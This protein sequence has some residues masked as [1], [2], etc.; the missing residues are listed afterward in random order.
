M[1]IKLL[2]IAVLALSF[3][4]ISF[5]QVTSIPQLPSENDSITIFF[6]AQLGSGNMKGYNG[7]LYTHTGVITNLSNGAWAYVIGT[8]G[9]NTQQPTLTRIGT[10]L[11]KLVIGNPH[12]Y[13][14]VP[15]TE[16]ILRLAFVFRSAD[17]K[18]Q[19]EDLFLPLFT[20]GLNVKVASPVA[21]FFANLNDSVNV[22]VSSSSA[23]S[24]SIYI[25]NTLTAQT[26]SS[27]TTFKVKATTTG[28][29]WIK[30]I[31]IDSNNFTKADSSY[32]VVNPNITVQ[33]E[34]TGIVD[35]I[36]YISNSSV[37]LSLY[38][39]QK[40]NVYVI[41]DFNNWIV[42]QNYY[43]KQTPDSSRW[44]IEINGLTP[45]KEYIFQYLVD[46]TINIADPYSE[47]ISDPNNDKYISDTTYPNL[48]QY[49]YGKTTQIASV[50]ETGQTPYQWHDSGFVP[51][52]KTNLVIYELLIRD[53][54]A[55][56]DYKTLA[57]TLSYFKRLGINAIELM[58]IMNFEGNDSWG[59][60][61]NF[62]D[63]PDKYYGP[64]DDLKKFIDMAHQDSIA[65]IL[66]IPF[67]DAFGS[68]PLVRLYWDPVNNIP[69]ANNPWFNQYPTH[70]YNV[71]YDFNHT[72]PAT[73]YFVDATTKFWLT[74]YH[75]DGFRFDLA[76]GYTQTYNPNNVGAWQSYDASR[77]IN[78]KRIANAIWNVSPGAYVILEEFVDG[79]EE[80]T[81][82]N[83]GMMVWDNM[84]SAY[85]QAAMGW[86]ANPSWDFSGISYKQWGWSVPGLVGYMESHDEERLMYKNLTY[87]NSNGSYNIKDL[88]TA[89]NRIK[90]CSAFFY[91]I[92]G[93]KMLW[94]F[95]ELGY[96]YS[97]N[98]NGRTGDKPIR[99]DYENDPRRMSLYKVTAAL[100]HLKTQ[101]PAFRSN[102]FNLNVSGAVK[103]INIYDNSMNVIVAGNFDVVN[104]TA[105]P[106]SSGT[107]YDYFTGS[108]LSATSSTSLNLAPGEFHIYTSVQLPV[109]DTSV[110]TDIKNNTSNQITNYA[111]DQNYP[112]PFNPSTIINYQLP[113]SSLVSLKIYDV[114][115]REVET[116]VNGEQ[117]S[118]NYTV[119]FNSS[120]KGISLPSGIYF[121]R[122]QAGSYIET[123]KMILMK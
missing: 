107:W 122:L 118:G 97:I 87:G 6:N 74:Q 63:A 72:S 43:M 58:P 30:A 105:T 82:A 100:I 32:F 41:G 75:A 104:H 106:F 88:E 1:K 19:T 93:P 9:N 29:T 84:S 95:Q 110:I 108:P 121:Y 67:N 37:I 86:A 23:K 80:D 65:V 103:Q 4:R 28:D 50:L 26:T 119:T 34:P 69:A 38:A 25:N 24:V 12:K 68:C 98:Y 8:W 17:A 13:Y 33:A 64:K 53:F 76:G 51:P 96:D 21:P 36:N 89:L 115:G 45:Q 91:T 70:P 46:G 102:G 112:N 42:D 81:V 31:A 109:P 62:F 61:P 49:P 15:S 71:G 94:E 39:P 2:L 48:I 16:K 10:D 92:P 83:Y 99:W 90:L 47:K 35:G 113:K 7:T 111:L 40:K 77:I 120:A 22:E 44:W 27:D 85:E 5:A 55:T 18:Q 14:G 60:N 78:Q 3:Y 123:K 101:Y 79:N 73:H 116:L 56:H 11:Y 66:D 59:Y 54:L 117:S 52:A 20:S 114:L 57:D